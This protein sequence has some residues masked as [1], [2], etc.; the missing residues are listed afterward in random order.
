MGSGRSPNAAFGTLPFHQKCVLRPAA[1]APML[2]KERLNIPWPNSQRT[3]A[4]RSHRLP[5]QHQTRQRRGEKIGEPANSSGPVTR[6]E[7]KNN[8]DEGEQDHRIA[9]DRPNRAIRLRSQLR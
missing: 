2:G 3:I 6:D 9:D 4:L 1:V 7:G 8:V 5:Q